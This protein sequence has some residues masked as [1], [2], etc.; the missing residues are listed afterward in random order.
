[1]KKFIPREK[2]SKKARKE[3]DKKNRATWGV[4][5]PITRTSKNPKIYDRKKVQKGSFEDSDLNLFAS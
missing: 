2:M 5:N 3:L 4:L 1:M